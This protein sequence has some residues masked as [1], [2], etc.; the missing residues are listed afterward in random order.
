MVLGLTYRSLIHFIFV[1]GLNKQTSLIL[2]HVAVQFS[3]HHLLKRLSF[4]YSV[5]LPP[6]SQ[7]NRPHKCGLFLGSLFCFIGLCV[8]FCAS[9]ITVLITIAL[10]YSLKSVNMIPSV[11]FF[12]KII[13]AIQ[14]HLCF[15]THFRIICCS[16]TVKNA[17][18]ID[19]WIRIALN[20]QIALGSMV[21]LTILIIPV[22]EH[23]RFLISTFS[24]FSDVMSYSFVWNIFFCLLILPNSLFISM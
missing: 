3:Q 1:Y 20:L 10:L 12:L 6:L 23:V 15:H 9:T 22:H 4:P 11:L 2:L 18:G 16:S 24:S 13:L 19:I 7:I 17:L 21:I 8:C 5:F 14:S